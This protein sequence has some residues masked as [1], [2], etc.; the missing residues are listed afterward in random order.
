MNIATIDQTLARMREEILEDI[1]THRVPISV[2]S[3][4]GLHD[5][6]DANAYGG[7]CDDEYAE[8]LITSF[9]GRDAETEAMPDAY[10]AFMSLAQTAIN[11]WLATGGPKEDMREYRTE[12]QIAEL[13]EFGELTVK[14]KQYQRL[15]E[16][17]LGR[18]EG[19][20]CERMDLAD[21]EMAV[22]ARKILE[23]TPHP[24]N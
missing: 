22:R 4:S 10:L 14:C 3:F 11:F 9:G 13:S 21:S 20:I 2:S 6:V 12:L 24:V 8:T 5:Y 17:L 19:C 15:A 7:F 18:Y 23:M 1:R 16:E